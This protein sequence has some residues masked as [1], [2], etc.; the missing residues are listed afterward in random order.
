VR[1]AGGALRAV[2][3]I[4]FTTERDFS[5]EELSA[6]EAAASSLPSGA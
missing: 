2:V 1:T 5:A 6:F 4:A 3:G